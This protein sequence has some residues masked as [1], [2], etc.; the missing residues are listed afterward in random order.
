MRPNLPTSRL[1]R[2][3]V[4][5]AVADAVLFTVALG[6]ITAPHPAPAATFEPPRNIQSDNG[7]G[8]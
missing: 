5:I 2:W 7:G 4:A 1:S 6:A 3:A 8:W